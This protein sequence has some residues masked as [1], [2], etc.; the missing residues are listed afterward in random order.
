MSK[1][2]YT[3]LQPVIEFQLP[4]MFASEKVLEQKVDIPKIIRVLSAKLDQIKIG[5][6][7]RKRSRG[8]ECEVSDH[9]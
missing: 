6:I 3:S 5:I 8:T 2:E 7:Y 1:L 4:Y 9:D